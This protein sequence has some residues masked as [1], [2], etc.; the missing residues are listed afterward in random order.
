MSGKSTQDWQKKLDQLGND[1]IR[2]NEQNQAAK[3]RKYK[4]ISAAFS[5]IG[6]MM[7]AVIFLESGNGLSDG[8]LVPLLL[9]N[10]IAGAVWDG[11]MGPAEN[12][13]GY[14]IAWGSS[15]VPCLLVL[16]FEIVTGGAGASEFVSALLFPLLLDCLPW[17]LGARFGRGIYESRVRK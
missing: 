10:V 11:T 7:L 12:E 4:M 1:L 3:L 13:Q 17:F 8:I 15:F 2:A 6:A 9:S 5:V 14:L 16:I